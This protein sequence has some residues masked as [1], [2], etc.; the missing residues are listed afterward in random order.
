MRKI[1]CNYCRAD[2]GNNVIHQCAIGAQKT[3]IYEPEISAN[4]QLLS[5]VIEKLQN[6]KYTL[7]V[8]VELT[9]APIWEIDEILELLYKLENEL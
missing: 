3:V 9:P 2:W 5:S 8:S 6:L 1:V 4:K 7:G